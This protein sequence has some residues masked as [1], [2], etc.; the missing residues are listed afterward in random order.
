[1]ARAHQPQR[2]ALWF[3]LHQ[4]AASIR[5]LAVSSQ[6]GADVEMTIGRKTGARC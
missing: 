1:V 5:D 2:W 3:P 6:W 4:L